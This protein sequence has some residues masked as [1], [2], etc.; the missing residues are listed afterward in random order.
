MTQGSGEA[1]EAP[2]LQFPSSLLQTGSS[3]WRVE[4]GCV[5]QEARSPNP[6]RWAL[7]S[8]SSSSISKAEWSWLSKQEALRKTGGAGRD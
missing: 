1:E 7:L 4:G 5:G 6:H 2:L 3:I 8:T